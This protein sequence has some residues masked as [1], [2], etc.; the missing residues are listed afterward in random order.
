[1]AFF[2]DDELSKKS[3]KR[4]GPKKGELTLSEDEKEVLDHLKR[5]TWPKGS[6]RYLPSA[7]RTSMRNYNR[8]LKRF[9]KVLKESVKE[10]PDGTIEKKGH[11][12]YDDLHEFIQHKLVN[13]FQPASTYLICWF[14]TLHGKVSHWKNW[15]GKIRPFTITSKEFQNEGFDLATDFGGNSSAKLWTRF[16][17]LISDEG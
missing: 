13:A 15:P 1:M 2:N 5:L 7:V 16:M 14:E 17:E 11:F 6:A 9:R 10:F 4:R 12:T 3:R 8:F